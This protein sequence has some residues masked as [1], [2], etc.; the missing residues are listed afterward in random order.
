[1]AKETVQSVERAFQII[2]LMAKNETMGIREIHHE[3][4]LR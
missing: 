4:D 3:T 2:E 1:M